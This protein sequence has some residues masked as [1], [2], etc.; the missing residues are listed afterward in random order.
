MWLAPSSQ[1]APD[2][3]IYVVEELKAVGK[4]GQIQPFFPRRGCRTKFQHSPAS[5]QLIADI[6][7]AFNSQTVQK[8]DARG[9]DGE[10][11]QRRRRLLQRA[12]LE[13][14]CVLARQW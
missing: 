1:K 11:S 7:Q 8:R 13:Q 2:A 12:P 3:G 6:H 4:S 10:P 14:L 5:R 9:I